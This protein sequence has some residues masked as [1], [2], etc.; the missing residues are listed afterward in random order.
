VFCE[1]EAVN[2]DDQCGCVHSPATMGD[3]ANDPA[4]DVL[5][6]NASLRLKV[7]GNKNNHPNRKTK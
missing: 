6:T 1:G 4:A 5:L 2:D 3:A 7:K